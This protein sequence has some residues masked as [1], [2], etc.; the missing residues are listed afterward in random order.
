M[1][2]GSGGGQVR[3]TSRTAAAIRGLHPGYF[4][5]V[6][7]TGIVSTGLFLLGPLWLSRV[8]LVIAS[9]G[10]I[11]LGVALAIRLTIFRANVVA[12]VKTPERVSGFFT[13]VA[14]LD[15]LGVRFDAAGHPVAAAIMAGLGAV[16]WL[17]LTYGVPASMLVARSR[18][19]VL[20]GVNGAWLLWVVGTQSL[21]VSASTL[22]SAW[23]SQSGLLAPGTVGCGALGWCST[24]CLCP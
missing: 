9:A 5:F 1:Q 19:S 12:D 22:A 6:M 21:S 15:V 24:C 18:D 7:A 10:L 16:V 20:S 4:A 2:T 8:L 23:P 14:G 3:A 13:I 17:V 11:V